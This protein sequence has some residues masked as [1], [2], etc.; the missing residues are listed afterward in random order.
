MR[1]TPPKTATFWVS[2]AIAILGWLGRFGI[3]GALSGYAF[4]LVSI[5]FILLALALLVKGL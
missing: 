5:A 1:L 3:I 2:V 4:V